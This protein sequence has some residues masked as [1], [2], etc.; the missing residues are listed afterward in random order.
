MKV[1]RWLASIAASLLTTAADSGARGDDVPTFADGAE[2]AEDDVD[3][4]AAL[5]FNPLD[6]A[7][8]VFGA[9][10]D[11]A[12]T[13]HLAIAAEAAVI[14]QGG[15]AGAGLGVGLLVYPLRGVF[16]GLYLEPRVV[17]SRPLREP[18]TQ[19][20]WRVDAVA[21]GGLAGW[22]W[23]WPYGLSI[24]VGAGALVREGARAPLPGAS[25]GQT[26][27]VAVLDGSVGWTF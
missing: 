22:H 10:A 1:R 17:Y 24:R 8:G 3:R 23:T 13:R 9:E 18:V 25:V 21:A 19:I 12:V 27:L 15:G 20:D 5:L 26:R 11:F 7:V 6:F 4:G 14:R 2:G 16:R